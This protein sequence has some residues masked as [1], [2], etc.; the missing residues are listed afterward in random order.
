MTMTEVKDGGAAFPE[1]EPE[2]WLGKDA[3]I[4]VRALR[5]QNEVV[6]DSEG[7]EFSFS[8]GQA[9]KIVLA[10]IEAFNSERRAI[11]A[12]LAAREGRDG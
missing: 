3:R 2:Y 11:D 6:S 9:V 1:R 7:G 10:F 12:L 5:E 4:L 8:E